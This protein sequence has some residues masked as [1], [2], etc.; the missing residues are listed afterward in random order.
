MGVIFRF[1]FVKNRFWLVRSKLSARWDLVRSRKKYCLT[2]CLLGIISLFISPHF[3]LFSKQGFWKGSKIVHVTMM[4]T[5]NWWIQKISEHET[6]CPMLYALFWGIMGYM[7][8]FPIVQKSRVVRTLELANLY[9][10]YD[11]L[12]RGAQTT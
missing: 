8:K 10:F 3:F 11:L 2:N 6:C 7:K 4:D 1:F 12:L 5:E 9:S